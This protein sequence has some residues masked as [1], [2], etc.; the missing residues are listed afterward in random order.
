[1]GELLSVAFPATALALVAC[2]SAG[3]WHLWLDRG[4]A[5]E[6]VAQRKQRRALR[7]LV[8]EAGAKHD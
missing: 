6:R 1:M 5:R 2:R 4:A 8:R 7:R 3:L